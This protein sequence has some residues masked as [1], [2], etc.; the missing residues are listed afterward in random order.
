M[1]DRLHLA[2]P[3]LWV[4][5]IEQIHG[6]HL[7]ECRLVFPV[8]LPVAGQARQTVHALPL[9]RFIVVKFIWGARPRPDQA[10]L[11][12]KHVEDLG[13]FVQTAGAQN[14]PKRGQT[15]IA[16]SIELR[17]RT[18]DPHQFLEV[19]FMSLCLSA[20]LH[21]PELPDRKMSSPKTDT[22]LAVEDRAWR[23]ESRH[24]HEQDHQR[25]P[26]RKRKQ[27][28]GKIENRFPPRRFWLGRYRQPAPNV[29]NVR[30]RAHEAKL[31]PLVIRPRCRV[32]SCI[33]LIKLFQLSY[34]ANF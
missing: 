13:Q 8:Y 14:S 26:N 28:A 25:Q 27:N 34:P 22:L 20:Q 15:G 16:V 18:I 19:V 30:R 32:T 10:H 31:P 5:E 7:V 4:L 12:A 17:H 24:Q 11:A 6:D 1:N 2:A 23:G 33:D 3:V 9:P 21:C 29:N